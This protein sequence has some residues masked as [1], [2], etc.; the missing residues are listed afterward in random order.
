MKNSLSCTKINLC[1]GISPSEEEEINSLPIGSML[2]PEITHSTLNTNELNLD[3]WDEEPKMRLL[4]EFSS[5]QL[6]FN[7]VFAERHYCNLSH[8]IKH[9]VIRC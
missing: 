1:Q 6:E 3:C 2:I 7:D 5:S 4:R 9:Y 8:A